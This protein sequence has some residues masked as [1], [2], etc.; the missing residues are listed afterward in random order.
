MNL[1]QERAI[2]IQ[3]C[4]RMIMDHKFQLGYEGPDG[5]I[6]M[7]GDINSIEECELTV[8]ENCVEDNCFSTTSSME[9]ECKFSQKTGERL[10]RIFCIFNNERKRRGIPM[11][12]K[13]SLRKYCSRIKHKGKFSE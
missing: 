6:V 1:I 9:F 4:S 11:R 3:D 12:R 2:L 8:T 13:I 7:L 5:K 10:C